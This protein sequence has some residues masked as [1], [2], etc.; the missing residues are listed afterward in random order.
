MS[1]QIHM[2]LFYWR[3]KLALF[4]AKTINGDRSFQ[5]SKRTQKHFKKICGLNKWVVYTPV[6][7]NLNLSL[8]HNVYESSSMLDSWMNSY[9]S[10]LFSEW[11]NPV[12]TTGLN[13]SSTNWN[14]PTLTH[15]VIRSLQFNFNVFRTQ[16][17]FMSPGILKSRKEKSVHP[18]FHW[19]TFKRF[20]KLWISRV[21]FSC[22]QG[23]KWLY[24]RAG[25]GGSPEGPLRE[26]P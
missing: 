20:C 17:Y 21:L 18:L 12:H 9:E 15:T 24:W 1:L 25:A 13:D 6:F 2:T 14:D 4:H 26:E 10:D 16:S 11:V 5:A 23:W 8:V 22:F 19:R 7:H 3:P